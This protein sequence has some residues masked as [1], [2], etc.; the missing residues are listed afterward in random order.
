[1]RLA[2]WGR[3]PNSENHTVLP[4]C[5]GHFPALARDRGGGLGPE[6]QSTVRSGFQAQQVMSRPQGFLDFDVFSQAGPSAYQP[7][8]SEQSAAEN[9]I[10]RTKLLG[11]FGYKTLTEM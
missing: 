1:M 6:G 9:R 5:N 2:M 8:H 4:T 10:A 11:I 3:L 7:P